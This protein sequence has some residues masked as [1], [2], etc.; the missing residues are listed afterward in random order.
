MTHTLRNLL[1]FAGVLIGL[2]LFALL[3]LAPMPWKD[4]AMISAAIFL[5]ALILNRISQSRTVT[6]VLILFSVFSSFRYFAWRLGE[7]GRAWSAA[8][9]DAVGIDLIFV[10][11][12]LG[13]ESYALLIL[14]LGYF[15]TI[16]P[17][18]RKP[19]P[20]P[21]DPGEWP[22]IDVLVPTYNEPLDVVS[23]TVMAARQMDWPPEKMAVHI[24]DDGRR[25]EFKAFAEE[26]GVGYFTRND[27]AHAKAGN[28]NN[29][30]RKMSAEFVLIF[31]CDHIPTRSFLQMT[32]SWFL[33]DPKLAMLQTPHHF[34][35]PDPF[36]RNLRTF[37][38][39]PNEGSLF[40]GVVQDGN[41]LWNA[42]FFC[43]SAAVI[44]RCALMEIGGI[45]V[46]TVTEDAHTSL[47]LQRR[48]WNTA[49]ISLPMI[50]GLATATLSDHITQRIRWARGMV[51]ILRVENPLFAS[52]L[53]FAQ[54]LCYFNCMI[55]FL[56]ALPRLVFLT[57]PLVY[58]LLGR[59]N[60]YGYAAAILAYAFPHLAL[61]TITNSRMQ[62]KFRHSFWNEIYETVLSPYILLPTLAAL[63]NPR[64]GKFNVTP[65]ARSIEQTN[66]DWRIA[67]P[68]LILLA[69]N[70]AGLIAGVPRLFNDP[71]HLGTV[72]VNVL[73]TM[74]NV[75]TLAAALAA[76][77]EKRQVR[78]VYRVDLKAEAAVRL[79][80]GVMI[81]AETINV[82]LNGAALSAY[83][84]DAGLGDRVEVSMRAN[85]TEV[86]CAATV[87]DVRR[88][89]IRVAFDPLPLPEQENLTR[90]VFGRA[91]SWL[92]WGERCKIDHPMRS[93]AFI[94][95]TSLRGIKALI[96]DPFRPRPKSN[97]SPESNGLETN[98]GLGL[99]AGA[100]RGVVLP[101]ILLAGFLTLL[102]VAAKAA[103]ADPPAARSFSE[104]VDF[105]TLGYKSGL[106]IRGLTGRASLRFGLPVSKLVNTAKLRLQYHPAAGLV[107]AKSSFQVTLNGSPV[108]SF[109][110]TVNAEGASEIAA[111]LPGD[112]LVA[113]N[114]LQIVLSGD[115]PTCSGREQAEL[116]TTIDAAS[117]IEMEGTFF[118]LANDVRMLPAPFFFSSSEQSLK[119]P[120][121]FSGT[122][123]RA[124]LEAAGVVS[125]WLGILSDHRGASFPVSMG[126]MPVGNVVAFVTT[127]SPLATE[128]GL[129]NNSGPGIAVRDN[130]RDAFNKVL[131]ILG[132]SGSDF[133]T[134]ARALALQQVTGSGSYVPV[135]EVQLPP[136]RVADDAPRWLHTNQQAALVDKAESEQNTVYG[137]GIANVFFRIPPDLSFD[138]RTSVP[139]TVS[140]ESSKFGSGHAAIQVR[141]NGQHLGS[142][143]VSA[144]DA[145]RT[146]TK[147]YL[148]PVTAIY[149]RN[150]LSVEFSYQGSGSV[151]A[152]PEGRVVPGTRIDLRGIPRFVRLPR[153]DLFAKAGLPF[154]QMADLSGTAV[155]LPENPTPSEIATYLNMA[156]FLG[157]QT[158][159]PAIRIRVEDADAAQR[160][161]S[162]D[163]L[164]IGSASDQ[165]LFEDWSGAMP[166]SV[167]KAGWQSAW[168]GTLLE[169]IPGFARNETA[170]RTELQQILES[171]ST[172]TL[173]EGWTNPMA[174]NRAVVAIVERDSNADPRIGELLGKVADAGDANTTVIT[175]SDAGVRSFQAPAASL[176]RGEMSI[177]A[178]FDRWMQE[179]PLAIPGLALVLCFLGASMLAGSLDRRVLRRL[180]AEV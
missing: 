51:Q 135:S 61:A 85:G 28:I 73:W 74:A 119:L 22:T 162:R 146:I 126:D 47:R 34:Y 173:I 172:A 53:S 123:D 129:Q 140:V 169:K 10:L 91:D 32:M 36:E 75:W 117:E 177:V 79:P 30:L 102:A 170:A 15:Q 87:V 49:Y 55:H 29:A 96:A 176:D 134:A 82:S 5:A 54:R 76:A 163:L 130:P 155:V 113:E 153:M 40:Y 110:L 171:D 156:A 4:Q 133:M 92:R 62:G 17:L 33:K 70:V 39:V 94:L 69:G 168:R 115:C 141:L 2:V 58:L 167:G 160:E 7:T 136:A 139:L 63:I 84:S 99:A 23:A 111:D 179:N 78:K 109:P 68:F 26:I 174:T 165:P 38:T 43:G 16:R 42:T 89:T 142:I 37:R 108:V 64:W 101:L 71:E 166:V 137:D 178:W 104:K 11:L 14:A 147:T 60:F 27:N 154:T 151:N 98:G 132:A 66:L 131:V 25:P 124:G 31:D 149:P 65:K 150:T 57:S 95:L 164:V 144:A 138:S 128:L 125:S 152:T 103:P 180:R 48:G 83:S 107:P 35:S 9:W 161:K 8:G 56:Y 121:V 52:G 114:T 80:S 143:N 157:A 118:H 105:Q 67:T 46:E 120:F 18:G 77:E 50:G 158:G 45:A 3:V 175:Q 116:R 59:S 122:P 93:L 41:D 12:L 6:V 20:L 127:G 100:K 97:A 86:V 148:A 112:L 90:L 19:V 44:R 88:G 145:G 1:R 81:E 72:A 13:A 24:L 106:E 21:A 159:Y